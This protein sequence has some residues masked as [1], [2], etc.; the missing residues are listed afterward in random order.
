L[1]CRRSGHGGIR[2]GAGRDS[3][4]HRSRQDGRRVCK[5]PG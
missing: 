2:Y 4:R 5:A 3:R 1:Q